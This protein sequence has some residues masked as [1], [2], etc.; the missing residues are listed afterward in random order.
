MSPDE[1]TRIHTRLDEQQEILEE[2]KTAIVGPLDG[3]AKGMRAS[4]SD[5]TEQIDYLKDK[6][7]KCRAK[8]LAAAG[9]SGGVIAAIGSNIDK[10]TGWLN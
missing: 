3:S 5:N 8:G 9:G 4:I 6:N 1:A 7:K 2:I 10:I